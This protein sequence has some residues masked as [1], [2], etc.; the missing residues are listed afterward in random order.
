M[1][2]MIFPVL[3]YLGSVALLISTAKPGSHVGQANI[4]IFG[5]A[6]W[7]LTV[8]LNVF[9]T[10]MISVR[11]WKYNSRHLAIG[12]V[13]VEYIG[14]A[15]IFLDS[16]ALYSCVRLIYIGLFAKNIPLQYPLTA[17]W[18]SVTSIAPNLIILRIAL[19]I[20]VVETERLLSKGE[21]PVPDTKTKV[22]SEN[23]AGPGMGSS[24]SRES[25]ELVNTI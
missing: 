5:T 19:G 3:L 7:T 25:I 24:R 2:L 21:L 20:D 12:N 6:T 14:L 8:S 23:Y 4:K 18:S 1:P 17:L 13:P 9:C 16:G 10:V 22:V 11:L 15:A